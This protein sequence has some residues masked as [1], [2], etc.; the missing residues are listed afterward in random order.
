MARF[1]LPATAL[2]FAAEALDTQLDDAPTYEFGGLEYGPASL[3]VTLLLIWP[4]F[5][6][7]IRRFHDLNMTGWW[8]ISYLPLYMWMPTSFDFGEIARLTG[9]QK[10]LLFGWAITAMAG[11]ILGLAQLFVPGKRGENRFGSDP[12]AK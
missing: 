11:V 12:L 9:I 6:T 2:G 7:S 4:T 1:F 8:T 3:A 5:A 10:L